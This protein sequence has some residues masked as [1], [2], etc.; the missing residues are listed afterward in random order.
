MAHVG[1]VGCR[2]ETRATL[3]RKYEFAG[4]YGVVYLYKLADENG[5]ILTW[6]TSTIMSGTKNR[7][8]SD[9]VDFVRKGDTVTMKATVKEHGSY[10]GEDQTVLSRVKVLKIDHAPTKD[11]TD[12]AKREE[13]LASLRDGDETILM[14]YARYKAHYSDC[15][16]L[17]GTYRDRDENGNPTQATVW[18]IVR[19]GRIVKSGVR[20]QHFY[21]WA[22]ANGETGERASFRA[23]SRENAEKQLA[24]LV[25]DTTGWEY[26]QRW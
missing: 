17:A 5:N 12:A 23:V 8:G 22:F 18:V 19:A 4:V 14:T 7:N 1:T 21:R 15:E 3:V 11:E 9:D 26:K 16:A 24:K 13:Q 2:I 6:K 10:K 20:G 25:G